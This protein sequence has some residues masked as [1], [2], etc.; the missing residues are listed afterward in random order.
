M[1]RR[2]T[3][4]GRPYDACVREEVVH[5]LGLGHT[6]P[7]F[8]PARGE[9]YVVG[10]S[11]V[12]SGDERVPV[13][14]VDTAALAAATGFYSTAEDLCRYAAAHFWSDETAAHRCV[15][16]AHATRVV[17]GRRCR[18]KRLRAG[19]QHHRVRRPAA[20]WSRRW[21]SGAHHAD[22][23]RPRCT[24]GRVGADERYRPPCRGARYRHREGHRP[25]GPAGAATES[26][27]RATSAP[28]WPTFGASATWPASA[29][30][31]TSSTPRWQSPRNPLW[32][33]T[34]EDDVTLRATDGPRFGAPG[35]LM[36]FEFGDRGVVRTVRGPGG[37]TWWPIDD[38]RAPHGGVP[39]P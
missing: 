20:A 34:V 22:P 36:H 29:S 9:D 3:A 4:S 38:Y 10:Y 28:A 1:V 25:C 16:A 26:G 12:A 6:G 31:F 24:P 32:T 2:R 23:V 7:D 35:E 14:H 21:L 33:V 17:A 13:A 27:H 15:E 18:R 8:D 37:M 39:A 19:V 30:G 11:G 5:R